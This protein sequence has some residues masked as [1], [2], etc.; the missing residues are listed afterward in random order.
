[1]RLDETQG[2]QAEPLDLDSA[3]LYLR[4]TDTTE[5]EQIADM[6]AAARELFEQETGRKVINTEY[7]G[8]LDDFPSY[9]GQSL[10]DY[11]GW[12]YGHDVWRG[13]SVPIRVLKPPL[14]AVAS[15]S[16]RDPS[17][18]AFV[19][20][21][22]T[23]YE[24]A[25]FGGPFA[26]YG[27]IYPIEGE[28]WPSVACLPNSVVVA[29]T[30]GYG[31]GPAQVPGSIKQTIRALLAEFYEFRSASSGLSVTADRKVLDRLFARYRLPVYA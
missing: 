14:Q 24:T 27:F 6:I 7:R 21:P 25:T 13:G 18:N 23:D 26:R 10:G 1:M 11:T 8:V 29:F 22:D 31:A 20:M 2:P 4:V 19:T 15:V 5:D 30:A 12:Q 16:Y 9:Q 28:V 3:K 17:T